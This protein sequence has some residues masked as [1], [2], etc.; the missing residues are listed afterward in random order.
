ML[1]AVRVEGVAF[2][3]LRSKLRDPDDLDVQMSHDFA[4]TSTEH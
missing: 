3:R 1:H 2:T 4:L